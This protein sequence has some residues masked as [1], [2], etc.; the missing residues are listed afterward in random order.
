[1][2]QKK[3]SLYAKKFVYRKAAIKLHC[4]ASFNIICASYLAVF[5]CAVSVTNFRDVSCRSC[6]E[7][8]SLWGRATGI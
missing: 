2:R 3:K 5:F 4:I 6:Q 8:G 7:R 1:M